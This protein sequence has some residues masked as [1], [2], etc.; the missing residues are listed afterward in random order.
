MVGRSIRSVAACNYPKDKLEVIVV[1]DGSRD[2]TFFHMQHLRREFPD[3]VRLVRFIGNRSSGKQGHAIAAALIAQGAE[4]TL[5]SGPTNEP[6]PD[7][8][9]LV[10]VETAEQM[11]KAAQAALPVDI[12]VCAAAVADWSVANAAPSK[13]RP[14]VSF[15]SLVFMRFLK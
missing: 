12:A 6:T 13:A 8:V 10:K 15:T 14:Q 4:V 5:I 7:G 1:D 3:L 11:L 9:K 2:D